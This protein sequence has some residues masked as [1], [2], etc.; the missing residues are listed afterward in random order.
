MIEGIEKICEDYGIRYAFIGCSIG[1]LRKATFMYAVPKPEAKI[2]A[3]YSAPF[4][5]AGPVEF[6]GGLGVVCEGEK[7]EKLTHF[8]GTVSDKLGRVY[9]G[10]F[11]KG[12]NA[13]LATIDLII[14]EIKGAKL[15]RKYD[16]ET[17]LVNFVP[18]PEMA[19]SS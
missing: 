3:G 9:G 12:Q 10:H 17:G 15:L 5:L 8:H 2:K 6:L 18:E 14:I 1:S 13:I 11:V 4:E 16:E 19:T 7:G